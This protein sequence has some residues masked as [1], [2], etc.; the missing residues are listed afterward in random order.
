MQVWI[1]NQAKQ[2]TAFRPKTPGF[3]RLSQVHCRAF[4]GSC[5]ISYNSLS[6]VS[7][8]GTPSFNNISANSMFTW[9]IFLSKIKTAPSR[10]DLTLTTWRTQ[11]EIHPHSSGLNCWVFIAARRR[12][13]HSYR[14]K[15]NNDYSTT[16]ATCLSVWWSV[17]ESNHFEFISNLI[18]A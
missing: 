15:Q 9:C 1:T 18:I 17:G 5:I 2:P 13:Y 8:R 14:M 12:I 10:L 7:S 4:Q 16:K 6:L 3:Q 11:P